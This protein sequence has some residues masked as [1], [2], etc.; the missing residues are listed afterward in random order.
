MSS[1]KKEAKDGTYLATWV[2][3]ELVKLEMEHLDESESTDRVSYYDGYLQR[4]IWVQRPELFQ[5]PLETSV[6][7]ALAALC[8]HCPQGTRK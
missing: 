4:L 1:Y 5:L 6:A 3:W 7:L 8:V 2:L